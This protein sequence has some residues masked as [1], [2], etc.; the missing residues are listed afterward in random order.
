ML[1]KRYSKGSRIYFTFSLGNPKAS[2]FDSVFEESFFSIKVY[3]KGLIKHQPAKQYVGGIIDYFDYVELND[4]KKM[5]ELCDDPIEFGCRTSRIPE[6]EDVIG[7]VDKEFERENLSL[8]DDFEDSEN[9]FS[10]DELMKYDTEEF[11]NHEIA[12][13]TPFSIIVML[14]IYRA[15]ILLIMCLIIDEDINTMFIIVLLMSSRSH[16]DVNIINEMDNN[17]MATS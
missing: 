6:N 8:G 12:P 9:E 10:N 17:T 15:H 11:N 7:P 5:V 14:L 13:E 1:I 4:L 16:R 3:H 2:L